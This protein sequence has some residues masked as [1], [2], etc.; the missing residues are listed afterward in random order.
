M[1]ERSPALQVPLAV[2]GLGALFPGSRSAAAFWRDVLAGRDL[3]GEIPPHYWRTEDFY[4]PDPRKP[5]KTYSK[6]GAFLSPID[7]D[8]VEF[9]IP[10]NALPT[11]DTCQL[12]SLLVARQ[13]LQDVPSVRSGRIARDRISVILGVTAGLE[14]VGEMASRTQ[15]PVWTK[16]L[17]EHGLP[18]GDVQEICRRI[19]GHY[20]EW[21]E[22]TFPGL[23]GNLVS[24]RIANHFDL[25]GTN[26]TSDAACA[27]S[28]SALA[29]AAYELWL[30]KADLAITGGADTTNDPFVYLCFSKTPAMSR[31]GDCR[32]FD[33][34][35]DGTTLG[36][37]LGMVA[38][39]RLEDAEK[40][41]DRI[42]AVIR[43]VGSS[44]D[45]HAGS[46]YAPRPDGQARALRE[47]YEAAGYGPD[48]VE[49]V[50]AHGTATVAGD[51]AEFAA[52][53]GVFAASGRRDRQW[54]A[55]G[56]VKSQ[57]GHTKGA[58]AA[59]GLLKVVLALQGKALPPTLKVTQP[60]SKL[61]IDDSPFYLNSQS[62]PWIRGGGHPRRASVSSFGFGGTNFHVTLEEYRGARALS[63]RPRPPGPELLVLGA[64]DRAQLIARC[65]EMSAA[66]ADGAL[67]HLARESQLGGTAAGA[68]LSV[69][70]GD[71]KDLADKLEHAVAALESR[72]DASLLVQRGIC[73]SDEAP[74]G[75][76]SVL[77]PGQGSQYLGMGA[78]LLMAFDAARAVW[79]RE[80]GAPVSGD[81]PLHQVVFPRPAFTEPAR[82]DLAR[83]LTATEWAQPAICAVS[84]SMWAL[85]GAVGVRPASAAGHSLGELTALYAAGALEEAE[86]LRLARRRGEL[87]AA[88]ARDAAEAGTMTAV[89]AGFAEVRPLLE[90]WRLDVVVANDNSPHQV[91]LSG[92]VSGIGEAERRLS[93][94]HISYQRLPVATAFH[95]PLVSGAAI[96]LAEALEGVR[97][98]PPHMPV[99]SGS[100]GAPLPGEAP[101]VREALA[102]GLV[103]PVR[104]VEQIEAMYAAGTRT[105]LEV[106]PGAVL[107]GLVS[108]CLAGRP[109][110]AVSVDRKGVPG[111]RA[112]W[113]ALGRLWT[114]G[115][116]LN[117]EPLWAEYDPGP[118]PRQA[119]KPAMK[120][121][122]D[123]ANLARG[124]P[125]P[126]GSEPVGPN[127]DPAPATPR[128]DAVTVEAVM[129]RKTDQGDLS[130]WLLTYQDMQRQLAEAHV[131]YQ[132][133]LTE[134]H[135]AFLKAA[136][137]CAAGLSN[138]LTGRVTDM[139]AEVV[140][141]ELPA[142]PAPAA[143]PLAPPS[144]E[145]MRAAPAQPFGVR[146]DLP[147]PVPAPAAPPAI[148]PPEVAVPAPPLSTAE[149]QELLI[150][151][152]A[153]STGYPRDILSLDM[154]LEGDL[155]IDSIKRVEIFSKVQERFPQLPKV[156]LP[157][158]AS[159]QTLGQVLAFVERVVA[160]RGPEGLDAPAATETPEAAAPAAM[161]RYAPV[162]RLRPAA[163]FAL[164]GLFEAGR[165]AVIDDGGGVGPALVE[166]L[167]G[168]GIE[169]RLAGTL[170]EDAAAAIHLGGLRDF[171]D[172]ESA[173]AANKQAFAVA[174]DLASRAGDARRLLVVVQDEGGDLGLSGK[175]G[176]RAWAGGF[177]G[178]IK[179]VALECPEG[180]WKAIDLERGGRS[181]AALA[182]GIV[183]ELLTGAGD[184]EVALDAKG[185]R[186][187][188]QMQE[189]AAAADGAAVPE[190]RPV[191]LVSGG[192][193]GV[194]AAALLEVARALKP[195]LVLIGRT[196][197]ADEPVD[198]ANERDEAA[199]KHAL[200]ERA[201][202]VGGPVSPAD[203]GAETRRI[204]A[205][206]QVRSSIA[207][208]EQAGAEVRYL[209]TDVRDQD[210]LRRAIEEVRAAWGPISGLI[211]GAGVLADKRIGEKTDEQFDAVF[212]TKVQGLR[213]LL[214]ATRADPLRHLIFFSSVAARLGN[215]GQ[216]DYAMANEVLNKV[217]AWEAR[218]RPDCNVRSLCWG[219]WDSGMVTPAL[220][221][222]FE[223]AG[224]PL[225]PAPDG[226]RQLLAEMQSANGASH[227]VVLG[228]WPHLAVSRNGAAETHERR[229]PILVSR[230]THPY[231]DGQGAEGGPAIPAVLAMEWFLRAGRMA[232][233]GWPLTAC[234]DFSVLEGIR[235]QNFENGGDRLEVRCVP[236]D[237]GSRASLALV[238]SAGRA[239]CTATLEAITTRAEDVAAGIPAPSNGDSGR[240]AV[241]RGARTMGWPDE[242][243]Q[244]DVAVLD[245]CLQ[246]AM[247]WAGEKRGRPMR[248]ARIGAYVPA[249]SGLAAGPV[250]CVLR[251][252][253]TGP[254][255]AAF[256][257]VLRD[258]DG[259]VLGVLQDVELAERIAPTRG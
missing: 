189:T 121:P 128:P 169:A 71:E 2:V 195:R 80:A 98:Q 170:P 56:S 14:L 74:S 38:L 136:E 47:A 221:R 223:Q 148:S 59:A 118:D 86:F 217:A 52:L 18:E 104:F 123:G 204:L 16:A 99:Y 111:L 15:R 226:A 106:G 50:E 211:H 246:L 144:V 188:V 234:R 34:H 164:P 70:A 142:I 51:A 191:L 75:H 147:L 153:D 228:D 27:S 55:L 26:C 5:D 175:A 237:G 219:P 41:G 241:V 259:A 180:T 129:E 64:D 3:I 32:P 199:L 231:L 185:N 109:H 63:R 157:D 192:A 1:H 163:G 60:A 213:A 214:D 172:S 238:D 215:T 7:F 186:W 202:A 114:A 156:D 42:Y 196:S 126:P 67:P 72:T 198:T 145:K 183:T 149:L 10:P 152:V 240:S 194:T 85:L 40:D 212:G 174:R 256:D 249:R 255:A 130:A 245:G 11:I 93:A 162:L 258:G 239:L 81:L 151:I 117:F 54:C 69:V 97:C 232:L 193:R 90:R 141:P 233:P 158:L 96:P 120:V 8:P 200:A 143:P 76:L 45:G 205:V 6:R 101:S 150:A 115:H 20:V 94:E 66:A 68:R 24:G 48:T 4:D 110:L 220:K 39:R 182:D 124:Y 49:L 140:L 31:S 135:V 190:E 160:G 12:L 92:T 222:A 43:G 61:R 102:Q 65:R 119:R 23:L 167:A 127:A 33:E 17:R 137:T 154:H 53:A 250:R 203:I 58:A 91:V 155:G 247:V 22:T 218:L 132:R 235:L 146:P 138:M 116:A 216:C 252:R 244:T 177:T 207:A 225:I 87:M 229:L 25:G 178:L 181:P 253:D 44:S 131:V 173:L 88:A 29:M 28:F 19:E 9:G 100:T 78:E 184:V 179:T 159:L 122:I 36:E 108:Q 254:E 187:T 242:A 107:T 89:A 171:A 176:L 113:Q 201:R 77:F 125:P 248:P 134:T 168:L 133:S 62:R 73:F 82:A 103:R 30:G 257:I 210:A 21:K 79:D 230:V 224:V 35:A 139:P 105:F 251:G 13:V 236:L 209:A 165:V 46:V 208:L 95:S 243:W 37:G 161:P 83:R 84:A 166:R 206:R 112:F 57:M 197:L 227:E